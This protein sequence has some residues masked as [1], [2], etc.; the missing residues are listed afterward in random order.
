MLQKA[1]VLVFA[2]ASIASCIC[3][4]S[5]SSHYVYATIPAASQVVA[6][7]EDPNSAVLTQIAGSPYV[8]GDGADSL[9]LHPSGKFLYVTNPGQNENDISLFTI[10]SNGALTEMFPRTSIGIGSLPQFMAMD[11][12][13]GFLYVANVQ[14]N[15][16]SVFA[17][18]SGSGA[19]TPVAG[20]PFP[21]GLTPLNMQLTPAGNYLYISAASTT[22][23][24]IAGFSVSAGTL[25]PQPVS[26]ISSD[27]LNPNGLAIDP[28]GTY[29]YAANSSSN[30]IS[31]FTIGP[32]GALTEVAGSLLNDIYTD[33]F[34]LI[35]DRSG[36]YLYVANQSSNNVALYPI[37]ANGVPATSTTTFAFST[38]S[39]PSFLVTDPSGK[40]LFV[41]N[42]GSS[43]GIQS[44]G[45]SNGNLTSLS[46]YGVGNTP[47]SI[48]VLQ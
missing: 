21:I 4:G 8:A 41:G 25:Q 22:H 23:G 42:Q 27:G 34:A 30:S 16:I 6:Y 48:A 29:L 19:L 14:S 18:D 43:A 2:L 3:C 1:L 5:T 33:P 17:I 7:R 13:G 10:A 35:L 20:S 9:V 12:A 24:W 44:F 45:V 47:S 15:D 26:L 32:S 36:K 11:P 31:T 37:G 28:S 40:Y 38:E 39:S 46:T